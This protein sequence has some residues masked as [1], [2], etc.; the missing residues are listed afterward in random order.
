MKNNEKTDGEIS[1]KG[2]ETPWEWDQ[3]LRLEFVLSRIDMSSSEVEENILK[4]KM[5][6][7]LLELK[8]ERSPLLL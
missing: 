1:S 5:E 4:V 8:K 6:I 2:L 3:D 7:N